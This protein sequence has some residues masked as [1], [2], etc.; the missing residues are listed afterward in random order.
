ML[1]GNIKVYVGE[2]GKLHFRNGSG[3]DSV[4]PF[5]G[6]ATSMR[7]RI[8]YDLPIGTGNDASSNRI[9]PP[10]NME[11]DTIQYSVNNEF[12]GS[13]FVRIFDGSSTILLT[14]MTAN[15][16]GTITNIS[17]RTSCIIGC[18][19]NG[20]STGG[21]PGSFYCDYTITFRNVTT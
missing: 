17:D 7:G 5:S 3:A 9:Y 14:I 16:S 13:N 15:K 18:Y 6:N 2:D 12:Y 19:R 4:L 21:A 20:Q 10:E 8:T 11:I 1:N